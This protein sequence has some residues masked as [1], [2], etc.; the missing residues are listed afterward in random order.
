MDINNVMGYLRNNADKLSK[1]Y[2]P[3]KLFDKIKVYAKKLGAKVVFAV[4]VLYY[5]TFD[6]ALPLKDRLMVVAALGYFILPLDLLPDALPGGFADDAAALMYVVKHI[7]SNLSP[8]T[9]IKA[10]AKVH[11]WFG[12]VDDTELTI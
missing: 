11:D 5:A 8:D 12:E 10:K 1:A 4:L 3:A 7:W 6:S 2:S 9:I